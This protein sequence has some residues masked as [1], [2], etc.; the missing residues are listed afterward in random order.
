MG[1]MFF[2]Y[3]SGKASSMDERKQSLTARQIGDIY[4]KKKKRM[5][6]SAA[7][8]IRRGDAA[9]GERSVLTEDSMVISRAERILK[10]Y[11]ESGGSDPGLL[12]PDGNEFRDRPPTI[13]GEDTFEDEILLVM[14]AR[15]QYQGML[16]KPREKKDPEAE[17]LF[18]YGLEEVT[19]LMEESVKLWFEASGLDPDSAEKLDPGIREKAAKQ[20]PSVISS[21][22]NTLCSFYE[23]VSSE[24]SEKTDR[25]VSS[26]NRRFIMMPISGFCS[27]GPVYDIPDTYM[28]QIRRGELSAE[29]VFMEEPGDTQRFFGVSVTG[30]HVGWL[31]IVYLFIPEENRTAE[32]IAD[33]LKYEIQSARQI[34]GNLYGV[35]TEIPM[36]E[37]YPA[38][39]E[40]LRMAGMEVKEEKGNMYRFRLSEI[41]EKDAMKKA[42]E[43]ASLCLLKDADRILLNRMESVM[44]EDPRPVAVSGETDW[45]E[46]RGD[47]SMI[48]LE[49]GKP[50]GLL[51][52]SEYGGCVVPELVYTASKTALVKLL[53][54]ALKQAEE[55]YPQDQEILVPIVAK[56]SREI[57][58]RIVPTGKRKASLT[59]MLWYDL[60]S[61]TGGNFVTADKPDRDNT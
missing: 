3:S 27:D 25:S 18:E 58:E 4:W 26:E 39:R 30:V 44:R 5:L 21:F 6:D 57:L 56:K 35:F 49:G 31:E 29:A 10:R 9:G 59:G 54:G 60:W 1:R 43:K 19:A 8:R 48:C 61:G 40:G 2:C 53:G 7:G 14:R 13:C 22:E 38:L 46:Y 16:K 33:F 45:K 42:A 51:L 32:A 28:L 55:L 15:D 41:L 20:L 50:V 23:Q 12:I 24:T 37:V 36:D 17:K 47:M 34:N 52:I 11:K